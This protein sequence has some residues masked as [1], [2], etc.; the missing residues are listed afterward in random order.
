MSIA[1]RK[2]NRPFDAKALP[3]ITPESESTLQKYKDEHTFS[4]DQGQKYLASWHIR[5][6]G[7]E[8]RIFFVPDYEQDCILICHVGGKLPNVSFPT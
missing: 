6:T 4:D 7:I 3:Y 2:K 1:Q 5:F 8:G